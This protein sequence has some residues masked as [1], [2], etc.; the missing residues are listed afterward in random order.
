MPK[1]VSSVSPKK[2][3][4]TVSVEDYFHV[5]AFEGAVRRKH[6]DRF[7]SRLERNVKEV[8]ELLD[9]FNTKA[10]FFVLGWVAERQPEIVAQ[11]A[12]HGHEI[13]SSAYWPRGLRGMVR[14]EFRE[15]LLRSKE[16][17]EA[18]GANRIVGY[19][20]ARDWLHED[21]LWV[22]D[23]LAEE[24]YEY[25]SSI[26]PILRRFARDPRRFK[27]HKHRHS[28]N[29][30]SIWEFPISTL[31][32]M[33][34]RMAISGGNYIRQFPHTLLR[35]ATARWD[36]RTNSPMVFY[37]M[38]WEFDREQPH[39]T[40]ISFLNKI[41]HYRNLAKTRWVLEDYFTKYQFQAIGDHLGI[42]WKEKPERAPVGSKAAHKS[43]IDVV[44]EDPAPVSDEDAEP[45]TLVIPLFNEE[46]NI[47]YLHRTLLDL[48]KRFRKKYR[49]H[50]NLVDDGSSDGT[51]SGLTSK[52]AGE[53]DCTVLKHPAN[54]GIAAAIMTGI[55][56]APTEIVCSIDCDCSYDPND[57]ES[58]I[59]MLGEADL[60][61][62]SPYH[63]QGEVFNVPKWRLFLSRTLSRFYSTLLRERFH[64]F[65][66]CCRVYR[67]SIVTKLQLRHGDFLGIAELLI[68]IKLAGG[69]V[70]EYPATLESRLF[71]ES[72]MKILRTIRGHLGLLSELAFKKRT[73]VLPMKAPEQPPVQSR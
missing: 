24:G 10:T 67:K 60:V 13:A 62:A 22:L 72:K 63:P 39:I 9:R 65:T 71:G 14:E 4:L 42:P 16:V 31:G 19:R 30:L 28:A 26:N 7:E 61:T 53:P 56:N 37:F 46:Q 48:R 49:I 21:N 32:L 17:I 55:Q 69:R 57:L 34:F 51:W 47:S 29:D 25:D 43:I 52:F 54:L 58:M 35:H 3:I 8:L 36:S 2:H 33:G 11:I 6:W 73:R 70:V 15:D 50:L 1:A 5:G 18:A 27:V 66:S 38:P 64:T 45:V 68:Q 20:A 41:R 23:V 59:S 12:T 40:S 44:T